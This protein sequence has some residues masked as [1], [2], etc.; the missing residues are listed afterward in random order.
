MPTYKDAYAKAGGADKLGD[1]AAWEKKA[2]AWNQKKY[3]T[4]EP[5]AK[6]KKMTGGSKTELAKEKA[7]IDHMVKTAQHTND[8]RIKASG[9]KIEGLRSADKKS[10]EIKTGYGDYTPGSNAANVFNNYGAVGGKG[11]VQRLS[12]I[13]VDLPKSATDTKSN[14]RIKQVVASAQGPKTRKEKRFDRRKEAG[15][16]TKEITTDNTGTVTK[17]IRKG[18]KTKKTVTRDSSGNKT[19]SRY[20]NP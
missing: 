3:G 20:R 12:A 16:R 8:N 14:E 17:T 6:A 13:A 15:R 2:K 1:Y 4:T 5:T 19:V 18:K 7:D 9:N 10:Y 11:H